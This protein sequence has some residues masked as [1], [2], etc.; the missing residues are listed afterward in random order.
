MDMRVLR[1]LIKEIFDELTIIPSMYISKSIKREAEKLVE[2]IDEK[3]APY[4]AL[5]IAINGSELITQDKKLI[6]GLKDK[7]KI[8]SLKELID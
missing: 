3:D 1:E 5:T 6:E 8:R 2:D 4:I 7:V